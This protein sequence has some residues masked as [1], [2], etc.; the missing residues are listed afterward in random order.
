MSI[1]QILVIIL[2]IFLSG[3]FWYGIQNFIEQRNQQ[4]EY[5][6]KLLMGLG[7]TQIMYFIR[8]YIE[9]GKL[10]QSE[11]DELEGMLCEPYLKLSGNK[12]IKAYMIKL[13]SMIN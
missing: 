5:R 8:S 2:T 1:W 7:Y 3:G 12:C 10:T 11:Y 9:A 6:E 4:N 13:K